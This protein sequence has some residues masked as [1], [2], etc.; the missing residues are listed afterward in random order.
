MYRVLYHV[1]HWPAEGL[2]DGLVQRH[3]HPF[4]YTDTALRLM[5]NSF[6]RL[7]FDSPAA[8]LC[9]SSSVCSALNTRLLPFYTSPRAL[10][11]AIP[12]VCLLRI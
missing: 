2:I 10:A 4:K 5:S 1:P 7:V 9:R 3:H 6:A 8:A 11:S 12:S